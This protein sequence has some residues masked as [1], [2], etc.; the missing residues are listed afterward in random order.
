MT[1]H[2]KQAVKAGPHTDGGKSDL[3]DKGAACEVGVFSDELIEWRHVPVVNS[4]VTY[5]A[6]LT[7]M[8]VSLSD[9]KEP[10]P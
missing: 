3:K 5:T 9:D 1:S 6:V 2:T 10:Q 7:P 4:A 8:V